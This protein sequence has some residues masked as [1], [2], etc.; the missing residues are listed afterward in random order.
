[1]LE[2]PFDTRTCPTP[3][4]LVPNFRL[5]L[6]KPSL[7]LGAL[8]LLL[9]S[10]CGPATVLVAADAH[11]GKHPPTLTGAGICEDSMARE[12]FTPLPRFFLHLPGEAGVLQSNP[13]GQKPITSVTVPHTQATSADKAIRPFSVE[14][15]APLKANPITS[16]GIIHLKVSIRGG[17]ESPMTVLRTPSRRESGWS[18]YVGSRTCPVPFT[19]T[20][21]CT[22]HPTRSWFAADHAATRTHRSTVPCVRGTRH[23]NSRPR[24]TG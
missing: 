3:R 10:V 4:Q 5:T 6:I 22:R 20:L 21:R 23:G 24:S 19:R 14:P 16:E 11:L 8:V 1:M 12:A 15:V 7:M 2:V 9:G 17:R 18:R 13:M